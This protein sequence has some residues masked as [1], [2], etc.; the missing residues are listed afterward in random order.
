[1]SGRALPSPTEGA[2]RWVRA[3][4]VGGAATGLSLL[5][6][7]AAGGSAPP[8]RWLLV[9]SL[10][11]LLVSVG[12]SG[13]RW[14]LGPLTGLLLGA[15]VVFHVAFGSGAAGH[16][17]GGQHL[18]H[19]AMMP[20]HSGVTMLAGHAVAAL[21]TALLLRRGEDCAWRAVDLLARAWRVARVTAAGRVVA[22]RAMTPVTVRVPAGLGL[23]EHVVARRGPPVLAAA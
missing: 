17:H 23:L 12:L 6:H 4:V 11:T 21:V 2:L 14:T 15:Q 7:V 8:A 19:A 9:L 13:R 16:V 20:G 3:S 1:V 5:G 18:G 10:V 22:G